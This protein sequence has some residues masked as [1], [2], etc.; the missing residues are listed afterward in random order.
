MG[1]LVL[2]R[3]VGESIILETESGEVIEIKVERFGAGGAKVH[4]GIKAP[5]SVAIWREELYLGEDDAGNQQTE[6][7]GQSDSEEGRIG[8]GSYR[9]SED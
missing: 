9:P 4:L 5:Q 2:G 6:A 3:R 1:H 7:N 8:V